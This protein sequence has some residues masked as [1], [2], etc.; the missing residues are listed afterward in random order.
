MSID[1]KQDSKKSFLKYSDIV[2]AVINFFII[3]FALIIFHENII[4]SI[5]G[6]Y[7]S[8]GIL[9]LA[10]YTFI[11]NNPLYLYYCYIILLFAILF[12]SLLLTKYLILGIFLIP[13][14]VYLYYLIGSNSHT[15]TINS[16][17]KQRFVM[18]AG[19]LYSFNAIRLTQQWDNISHELENQKLKRRDIIEKQY[20]AT[21]ISIISLVFAVS[22]FVI[23]ILITINYASGY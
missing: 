9:S 21:K 11:R 18:R 2:I 23:F 6:I 7:L 10:T 5:I 4:L 20:N 17:A 19:G 15:S 3:I 1:N 14:I 13:E 22:F 16:I 8:V 12:L